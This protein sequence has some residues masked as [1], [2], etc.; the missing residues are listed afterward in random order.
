MQNAVQDANSTDTEIVYE[1]RSEL[2]I[3]KILD[4]EE[5]W[6]KEAAVYFFLHFPD[7]NTLFDMFIAIFVLRTKE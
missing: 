3:G 2:T 5:F 7:Q 1:L 6:Q 4:L